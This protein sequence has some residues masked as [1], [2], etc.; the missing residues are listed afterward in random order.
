M[1]D[2]VCAACSAANLE[3]VGVT[4]SD[5]TNAVLLAPKRD[6]PFALEGAIFDKK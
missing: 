4:L 5:I 1:L 3:P 6:I 2:E